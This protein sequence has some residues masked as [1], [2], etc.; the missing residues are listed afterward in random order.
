[1][2]AEAVAASRSKQL[3]P[4]LGHF[5]P[6][7]TIRTGM[8]APAA[9]GRRV[10]GRRKPH[11]P[12]ASFLPGWRELLPRWDK[13]LTGRKSDHG[14]CRNLAVGVS[15]VSVCAQSSMPS[16]GPSVICL[17]ADPEHSTVVNSS[18]TFVPASAVFQLFTAFRRSRIRRRIPQRIYIVRHIDLDQRRRNVNRCAITQYSELRRTL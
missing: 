11:P 12:C 9:R 8:V 15:L 6:A 5:G 1:M 2:N 10:F 14:G 16:I 13:S 17:H 18:T 7:P 3:S 4:K